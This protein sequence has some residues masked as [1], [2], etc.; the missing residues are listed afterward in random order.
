MCRVYTERAT[1]VRTMVGSQGGAVPEDRCRQMVGAD[2]GGRARAR[3]FE[4]LV[5]PIEGDR[6][7]GSAGGGRGGASK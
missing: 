3:E 6:A 4:R 2:R 5:H 1:S 7:I